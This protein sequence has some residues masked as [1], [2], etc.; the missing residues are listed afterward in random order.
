M[1]LGVSGKQGS[2]V[3]SLLFHE[4]AFKRHRPKHGARA[5]CRNAQSN[6]QGPCFVRSATERLYFEAGRG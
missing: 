3:E 2:G 4:M 5:A 1:Q 6:M